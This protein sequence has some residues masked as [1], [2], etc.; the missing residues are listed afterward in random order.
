MIVLLLLGA[1]LCMGLAEQRYDVEYGDSLNLWVPR[2]PKSFEFTRKFSPNV[3]ILWKWGEPLTSLDERRKYMGIFFEMYNLTQKDMGIYRFRGKEQKELSTY[4]IE[5]KAKTKSFH[6]SPGKHL[7]FSAKLEPNFCN[8]YFFPEGTLRR[9]MSE[10]AIVRRGKLQRHLDELGLVGFDL[11][12]PCEI[13]IEAIQNTYRGRYEFRDENNDTALEVYLHV[14]DPTIRTSELKE[15]LQ[16]SCQGRYEIRDQDG[17]TALVMILEMEAPPAEHSAI[18]ISMGVFFSSLFVCVLRRCC[19]KGSSSENKTSEPEA[20]GPDVPYE[21]YDLEPV[22]LQPDQVSE[23]SGTPYR[24]QPPLT[25]TDPL[26]HNHPS[27]EMPPTYSEI[28][29]ASGQT[30]APTFPVHSDP[31]PRFEVKGMTLPSAPPLSSDSTISDV[32]TSSKLNFL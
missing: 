23:P 21:E 2:K 13:Y 3:T 19:C 5:V 22:R 6:K 32:Y 25:S 31:E 1:F 16:M 29:A 9:R 26:I 24:A 30:D 15:D 12:E 7:R 20:A 8:V 18:G 10:V 17:D 28:F 27:V 11:N 14:A 4:T